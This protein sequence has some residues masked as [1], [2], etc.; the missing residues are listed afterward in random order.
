MIPGRTAAGGTAG[1][2]VSD[3]KKK[4]KD[5]STP[6]GQE[7]E[8]PVA[9]ESAVSSSDG[10]GPP[11]AAEGAAP[12]A[13]LPAEDAVPSL[14][15]PAPELDVEELQA[16]LERARAAAEEYLDGWQRSRAEFANYKRRVDRELETARENAA[17]EILARYLG[18][19]D[20]LERA[21][22][23]R[24]TQGEAGAWAEGVELIYRKMKALLEMEGV[25]S[26]HPEGR[27]FD[28]NLHEAITHEESEGHQEGH[29]I[30]VIRAG[31]KLKDRVLRP[32]L[33]RV[34]K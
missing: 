10:G 5:T 15:A 2:M 23:N 30:E 16:E 6:E 20:D 33:V 17:G 31:Y 32:A 24:P 13:A 7:P 29:V 18:V 9:G 27:P 3:K 22:K 34:A 14:E 1:E 4:R 21:L 25:E 12:P 26:I 19:V 11:E 8:T 28:P